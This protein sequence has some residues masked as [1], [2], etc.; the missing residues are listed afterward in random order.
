MPTEKTVWNWAVAHPEFAAMRAH[1]VDVARAAA[2]AAQSVEDEARRAARAAARRAPGRT[3]RP[4]G[5]SAAVEAAIL[6]RLAEGRTL[7]S[8]CREPWAPSMGTVYGRLRRDPAFVEDYRAARAAAADMLVETAAE[9]SPWVGTEA[10]SMRLLE[11]R[12]RAASQRA[13]RISAK[14]YAYRQ[15]PQEVT[16]RLEAPDGSRELIYGPD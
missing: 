10:A 9:T 15:G 11:A 4:S 16:V 14:R 2:L 8:I 12:V 3:G 6:A 7:R 5:W 1:A 13:A